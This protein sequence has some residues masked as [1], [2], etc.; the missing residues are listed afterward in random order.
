MPRPSHPPWYNVR[1]EAEIVKFLILLNL[2]LLWRHNYNFDGTRKS[3]MNPWNRTLRCV[4]IKQCT[5]SSCTFLQKLLYVLWGPPCFLFNVPPLKW[6]GREADHSCLSRIEVKNEWS[7]NST[8][9]YA[10]VAWTGIIFQCQSNNTHSY[11]FTLLLLLL[12]L[13]SPWVGLGRDLSSVR[14]LVWLWYAASWASS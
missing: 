10:F 4:F 13:F 14:R 8:P 11:L 3:G 9:L 5:K 7:Y 1:W 2:V 12:L 6:P